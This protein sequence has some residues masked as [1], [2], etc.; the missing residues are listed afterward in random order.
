MR[1]RR[2]LSNDVDDDDDDDVAIFREGETKEPRHDDND[3]G[4]ESSKGTSFRAGERR[5]RILSNDVDDDDDD[6]KGD[7]EK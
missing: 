1:R 2:M 4:R 5:Q 7:V 3:G 6:E